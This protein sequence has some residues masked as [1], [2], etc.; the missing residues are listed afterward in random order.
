VQKVWDLRS[1]AT[2][3]CSPRT[4]PGALYAS[5]TTGLEVDATDDSIGVG[6][7][8]WYVR[9]AQHGP[10]RREL[11]DLDEHERKEIEQIVQQHLE[12]D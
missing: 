9:V 2:P 7:N 8:V 12:P 1:G 5:L 3:G 6:S 10:P 11:I 4:S